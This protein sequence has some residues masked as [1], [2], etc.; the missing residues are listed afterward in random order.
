MALPLAKFP[1][2]N[3]T[4][5]STGQEIKFRPF[6]VKEQKIILQ[7]IEFKD[8]ENFINAILNIVDSCTFNKLDIAKCTMYDIDYLFLHIRAR[9]IGEEVPV[10]YKCMAIIEKIDEDTEEYSNEVCNTKINVALDLTKI[11]VTSPP[12]FDEKRLIMVDDNLGMKLKSPNFENYKRLEKVDNIGK[13]FSVTERFIFDCVENIFDEK[14]VM[15]PNR[16][17]FEADFIEFLE[18]L[19][20]VAVQKINDFFNSM[21]HISLNVVVRCPKC[22]STD[23][24]ELRS[25]DDFFV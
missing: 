22:G 16:D 8:A 24:I 10:T 25:L 13:M 9:S 11:R 15:L 6:L 18:N 5:P 14:S 12:D 1:T 19:P 17:F 3:I 7:S 2:Y 21:P 20:T 4:V 23:Y